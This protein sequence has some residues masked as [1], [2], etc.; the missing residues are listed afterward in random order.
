M[1]T[2][3]NEIPM[4]TGNSGAVPVVSLTDRQ[5]VVEYPSFRGFISWSVASLS[6]EGMFVETQNPKAAGSR[7]SF[8][9]RILEPPPSGRV[10][11]RSRATDS[12]GGRGGPGAGRA[13]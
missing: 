9:L 5:L 12:C 13:G 6:E 1:S 8:V 4:A 3:V 11:F 7:L 2:E 10:S